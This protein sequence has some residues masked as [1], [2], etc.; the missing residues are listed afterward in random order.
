MNFYTL[1]AIVHSTPA[2]I[3]YNSTYFGTCF[4]GVGSLCN[5]T[6]ELHTFNKRGTN[7]V[8]LGFRSHPGS[9]NA[10][11]LQVVCSSIAR[12]AFNSVGW[13][14]ST[15]TAQPFKE[16]PK[17]IVRKAGTM[18]QWWSLHVDLLLIQTIFLAA[19]KHCTVLRR[20]PLWALGVIGCSPLV[21]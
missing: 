17:N 3:H 4:G 14:P 8:F 18:Q 12:I 16:N 20:D 10:L 19:N 1:Y 5:T 13:A 9:E 7:L 11:Y 6:W 15:C 2:E 21:G